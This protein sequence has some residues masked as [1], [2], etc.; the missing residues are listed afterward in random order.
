MS[1]PRQRRRWL[2][3]TCVALIGGLLALA[4]AEAQAQPAVLVVVGAPG[5][6]EYGERWKVAAEQWRAAA[7]AG[8]VESGQDAE[9]GAGFHLIGVEPDAAAKPDRER[10]REWLAAVPADGARPLW[11]VYLGHGTFDEREAR[12]NLRGPDVT[13][14]EL[15]GWVAHVKRPLVFV[16]GGSASGPFLPALKGPDRILITATIQGDQVNYARFGER[17]AAAIGSEAADL[18]QDGQTSVLEAFV[19]AAAEV[20]RFYADDGRMATEAALLDDNGD[21]RGTPAEWFSGT[22]ATRAAKDG[23]AL[24]GARAHRIAL[25][26]TP[27]ERALTTEQRAT[28][29]RLEAELE[30]VRGREKELPEGDYLREIEPILRALGQ[31]YGPGDAAAVG[32][33]TKGDAADGDATKGDAAKR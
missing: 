19:S 17:F 4:P 3:N 13:P 1:G 2:K 21:G 28:R 6:T 25:I 20:G 18:D 27:A 23:A 10:L 7:L 33:A 12:L 29:D 15:A 24:D 16:H 8:G 22:R 26:E 11:L 5:E 32:D 31:V 30:A 14:A 9:P